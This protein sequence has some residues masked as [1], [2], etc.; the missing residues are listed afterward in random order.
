MVDGGQQRGN[1]GGGGRGA[2]GRRGGFSGEIAI[3]DSA[4]HVANGST[5]YLYLVRIRHWTRHDVGTRI[6]TSALGEL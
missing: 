4:A 3:L 2:G 5:L 6:G 1:L